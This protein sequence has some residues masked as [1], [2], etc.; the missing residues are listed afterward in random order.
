MLHLCP[1]GA[2]LVIVL[3]RCYRK[4]LQDLGEIKCG[5]MRDLHLV[6]G[7]SYASCILFDWSSLS[8][9]VEGNQRKLHCPQ[10]GSSPPGSSVLLL[11]V[12]AIRKEDAGIQVN[13]INQSPLP[14]ESFNLFSKY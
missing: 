13:P 4:D 9:L 14:M 5:G 10:W 6:K 7:G 8:L 2:S 1:F 11:E 3:S 12:E